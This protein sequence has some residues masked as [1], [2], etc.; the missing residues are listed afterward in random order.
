MNFL[1]SS[2]S[3]FFLLIFKANQQREGKKKREASSCLKPE[4][5]A[6]NCWDSDSN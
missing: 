5:L 6:K 4:A 2:C 3:F 1:Q